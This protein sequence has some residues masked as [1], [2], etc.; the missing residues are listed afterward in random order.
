MLKHADP[1]TLFASGKLIRGALA[2]A[3]R[4]EADAIL[5]EADASGDAKAIKKAENAEERISQSIR[6]RLPLEI[7][8]AESAWRKS[9]TLP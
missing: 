6:K 5:R 8:G 3:I 2:K 1:E 4:E 9:R 7:R